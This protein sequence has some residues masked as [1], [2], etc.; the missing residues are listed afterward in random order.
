M[1]R[2]R[3]TY[4][5]APSMR[6]R[7]W[8]AMGV[9][10]LLHIAIVGSIVYIAR[11]LGRRAAMDVPAITFVMSQVGGGTDSQKGAPAPESA[12]PAEPPAP[13][14]PAAE[15]EP[16]KPEPAKEPEPPKP[17]P[18]KE[19]PKKEVK[20]EEVKKPDIAKPDPPKEK[21][22]KKEDKKE[23]EKPKDKAE[24]PKEAKKP[25][26][27]KKKAPPKDPLEPDPLAEY[28]PAKNAPRAYDSFKTGDGTDLGT[29]P[30][31]S[32]TAAGPAI[33][34]PRGTG[35]GG[36]PGVLNAWAGLVQRKVLKVWQE[37]AGVRLAPGQNQVLVTFWVDRQGNIIGQPQ[38]S[39]PA[40]P[41]LDESG[42]NAILAAA[43]LPPLP[44][45]FPGMEQQVVFGFSLD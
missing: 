27:D 41:L 39:Q 17:E 31:V 34:G 5:P 16:P 3:R 18:K 30:N 15:P 35:I 7:F 9:S 40:D 42:I 8:R 20:K 44:E 12:R 11:E 19:E 33:E 25:E 14:P 26:K 22:K 28:K 1:L 32:G 21:E 10:V 43:P 38:V 6:G 13:E 45:D 37:P 29:D 4:Y 2:R 24:K 36:V 23:A